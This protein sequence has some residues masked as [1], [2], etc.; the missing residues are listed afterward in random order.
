MQC[1]WRK[2]AFTPPAERGEYIAAK[3][4]LD[5]SKVSDVDELK[6]FLMRRAIQTIPILLSLQDNGSSI[7]R[8]Y[9]RGMLT[10]D[11]HYQVKELKAFVDQEFQDV[12]CE[13][14]DLLAGWGANIW[15]Q[16]MQF[17]KV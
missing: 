9:K 5:T 11:M 3:E 16:A 1:S 6:K 13:A 4:R 12:Q 8:L 2:S 10:D 7:E 15:P 17:H 14:E